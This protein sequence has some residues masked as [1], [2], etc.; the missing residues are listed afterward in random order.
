MKYGCRQAECIVPWVE[1]D[2]TLYHL[3]RETFFKNFVNLNKFTHGGEQQFDVKSAELLLPRHHP[4]LFFL[5][6][7]SLDLFSVD[8]KMLKYSRYQRS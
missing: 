1:A 2:V 5:R 6:F 4:I 8:P 3:S 7:T